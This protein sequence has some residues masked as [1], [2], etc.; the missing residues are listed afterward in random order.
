M[1]KQCTQHHD[2][3]GSTVTFRILALQEMSFPRTH[4]SFGETTPPAL[5][6]GASA[7]ARDSMRSKTLSVV[8][9]WPPLAAPH[10]STQRHDSD[11]HKTGVDH[12]PPSTYRRTQAVESIRSHHALTPHKSP[13]TKT[14]PTSLQLALYLMVTI[15]APAVEMWDSCSQ[16]PGTTAVAKASKSQKAK[17]SRPPAVRRRKSATEFIPYPRDKVNTREERRREACAAMPLSL[18]RC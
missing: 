4:G 16:W 17:S 6:S 3:R 7:T 2:C 9:L 11:V 13:T 12:Q 8:Y 18:R 15:P 14:I 1:E 10:T 5:P